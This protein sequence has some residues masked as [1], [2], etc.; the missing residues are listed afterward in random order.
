MTKHICPTHLAE[1]QDLGGLYPSVDDAVD[2]REQGIGGLPAAHAHHLCSSMSASLAHHLCITCVLPVLTTPVLHLRITCASSA[3]H[4]RITRT[5]ASVHH[6]CITCAS[7]VHHPYN[8][9]NAWSSRHQSISRGRQE[10]WHENSS[11][12]M[13]AKSNRNPAT[14]RMRCSVSA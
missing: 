2:C 9:I 6:L 3:H 14:H 10:P 8:G 5:T 12:V 1:V 7:L 4:W 13:H 11:L